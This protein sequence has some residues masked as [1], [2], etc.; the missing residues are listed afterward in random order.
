MIQQLVGIVLS[1]LVASMTQDVGEI[2]QFQEAVS[3]FEAAVA[4]SE[5]WKS[6]DVIAKTSQTCDGTRELPTGEISGNFYQKTSHERT[7]FNYAEGLS[8]TYRHNIEE[9][10]DFDLGG[11]NETKTSWS[12]LLIDQKNDRYSLIYSGNG[13]RVS[14]EKGKL[15]QPAA[16]P[17]L[18]FGLDYRG[19][20]RVG[21]APV[22][23]FQTSKKIV[24][25]VSGRSPDAFSVS[26]KKSKTLVAFRSKV[27]GPGFPATT[28][29]TFDSRT[30]APIALKA[31]Y[32]ALRQEHTVLDWSLRWREIDGVLV[33]SFFQRERQNAKISFGTK[34][35]SGLLQSDSKFHWFSLNAD[36]DSSIFDLSRISS[37]EDILKFT[38]PVATGAK[39]IAIDTPHEN[40]AK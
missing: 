14:K 38:D 5:A 40:L 24:A 1:L 36:V 29:T 22:D 20:W 8:V 26:H 18:K 25:A 21:D 17:L 34:V 19:L 37:V 11:I 32:S 35:A 4:N 39:S 9:L 30:L 15:S 7:A 31:K 13:R 3:Y 23:S 2:D 10:V 28:T 27:R 33:P 16:K 6:G 12:A